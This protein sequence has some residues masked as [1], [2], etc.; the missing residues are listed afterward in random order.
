MVD[1]E[2]G[3]LAPLLTLLSL[4][5]LLLPLQPGLA[6]LL[7]TISFGTRLES[8]SCSRMRVLRGSVQGGQEAIDIQ[9]VQRKGGAWEL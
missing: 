1:A 3:W 2:A 5:H 6:L 9:G 4:Y 7:G 8:A